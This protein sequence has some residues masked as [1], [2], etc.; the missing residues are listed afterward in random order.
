MTPFEQFERARSFKFINVFQL[1]KRVRRATRNGKVFNKVIDMHK[2]STDR[3]QQNRVLLARMGLRSAE[4]TL[5]IAKYYCGAFN[6]PT[7]GDNAF[8]L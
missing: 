6:I 7:S 3:Y 5:R 1:A 4:R 8:S 2:G